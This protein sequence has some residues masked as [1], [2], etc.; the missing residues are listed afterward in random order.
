MNRRTGISL[1]CLGVFAVAGAAAALADERECDAPIADWRPRSAVSNM[2]AAKGWTLERLRVD[3]GC[4]KLRVLDAQGRRLKVML[5]PVTLEV[6]STRTREER[7]GRES[8][9]R[10][11]H[12]RGSHARDLHARDPHARGA[13]AGASDPTAPQDLSQDLSQGASQDASQDVSQPPAKAEIR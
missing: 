6:L 11:P 9:E 7:R 13:G 2:A 4:Y 1:A 10:E 5:D 12:A 8:H 3:D